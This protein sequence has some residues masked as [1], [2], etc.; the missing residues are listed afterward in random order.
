MLYDVQEGVYERLTSELS[1]RD[2]SVSWL[3]ERIGMPQRTLAGQFQ[4]KAFSLETVVRAAEV[5]SVH[6]E[7][8]ITGQG[9][10]GKG[11]SDLPT[12]IQTD[13]EL[14]QMVSEVSAAVREV[15]GRRRLSRTGEAR[16]AQS[17]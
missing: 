14:D 2:R 5:L 6:L 4:R 1:R 8:L 7:W 15:L 11:F 10:P 9:F 13:A 3:A 17:S 12:P 16:R